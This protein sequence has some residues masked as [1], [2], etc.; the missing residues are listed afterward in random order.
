MI[1]SDGG[2]AIL[3]RLHDL[4]SDDGKAAKLRLAALRKVLAEH[5]ALGSG[6]TIAMEDLKIRGAGNLLGVEQSGH[7]SAVGFDL[8]CRLLREAV[9]GI[10]EGNR[11]ASLV[12]RP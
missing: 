7:I 4:A 11:V 8:Y 12:E 9:T 5:T 6:F 2:D 10:R 1:A 3:R